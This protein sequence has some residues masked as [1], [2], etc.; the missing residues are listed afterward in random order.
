MTERE[1]RAVLGANLKRYRCFRGLSQAKLAEM[2]DISP[3][4]IS[5][6]ET[7]KRWISSDTMVN[8]AE[9]LNVE[10]FEFLKP[11]KPQPDEIAEVI[12]RYTSEAASTINTLVGEALENLRK[13][14][15]SK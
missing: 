8:L 6:I 15:L 10:V 13:Q 3:N 9:A 2:V 7:G 11:G 12:T 5:D 14:Y 4:F 1:L